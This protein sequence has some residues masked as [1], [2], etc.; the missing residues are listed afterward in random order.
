MMAHLD[1][2]AEL[3]G[4][5]YNWV[6][7]L[8]M[9]GGIVEPLEVPQTV[10]WRDKGVTRESES[11]VKMHFKIVGSEIAGE[12]TFYILPWDTD[13]LVIGWEAMRQLQLLGKL[14]DL[15]VI[16]EAEGLTTGVS[17]SD[18]NRELT[19][20]NGRAM[21]TDELLFADEPEIEAPPP[22]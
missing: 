1:S 20:M 18:G 17:T 13:H 7:Y 6:P 5:G 15:I 11:V 3:D 22:R 21:S 19:D 2:G 12:L 14:E 8:E 9:Y 10:E 4:V 16:Q